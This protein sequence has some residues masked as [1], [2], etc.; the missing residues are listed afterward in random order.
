MWPLARP[1]TNQREKAQV[2][3]ISAHNNSA[4]GDMVAEAVEKVGAEGAAAS[5]GS[6]LKKRRRI[7]TRRS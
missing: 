3:A 5:C 1:V 6:R 4:I 7:M 2:A